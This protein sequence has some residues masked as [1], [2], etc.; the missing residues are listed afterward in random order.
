MCWGKRVLHLPLAIMLSFLFLLVKGNNTVFFQAYS[1]IRSMCLMCLCPLSIQ[2]HNIT[3]A[4][5]AVHCSCLTLY[6]YL[7]LSASH[8]GIIPLLVHTS[9]TSTFIFMSLNWSHC[10]GFFP[11][12]LF[13][14]AI[15]M[16][17]IHCKE[18]EKLLT[19]AGCIW[20]DDCTCYAIKPVNLHSSS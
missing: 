13:F 8:R 18:C 7:L 6:Q 4:T 16:F 9:H 19:S 15:T 10:L 2:P 11:L 17:L 14:S 20:F 12:K 1:V 5:A 3:W